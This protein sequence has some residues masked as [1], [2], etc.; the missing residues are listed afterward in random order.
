MIYFKEALLNNWAEEY[1]AKKEAKEEKKVLKLEN[2][3]SIEEA[4]IV[5]SKEKENNFNWEEF[6]KLPQ[7]VQEEITAAA[8][9]DYLLEAETTDSK[10]IRGIFEKGKKMND[11]VFVIPH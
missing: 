7:L 3:S 10:L 8:Y 9:E 4:V 2:T 1:I 6:L 5:E 11:V